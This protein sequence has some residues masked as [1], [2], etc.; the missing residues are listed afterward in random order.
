VGVSRWIDSINGIFQGMIAVFFSAPKLLVVLAL[1]FLLIG[2]PM[3][4]ALTI[5]IRRNKESD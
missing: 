5:L 3:M 4:A 1:L 2:V